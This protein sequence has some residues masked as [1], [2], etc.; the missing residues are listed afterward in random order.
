MNGA[1]NTNLFAVYTHVGKPH[2]VWCG[3]GCACVCPCVC[4]C[5]CAF[6]WPWEH[7][8]VVSHNANW[9]LFELNSRTC[10]RQRQHQQMPYE[11]GKQK[12]KKKQKKQ[13]QSLPGKAGKYLTVNDSSYQITSTAKI[14]NTCAQVL[15]DFIMPAT[16]PIISQSGQQM[17]TVVAGISA[18]PLCPPPPSV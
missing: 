8:I 16:L 5:V 15:S 12:K 10:H 1:I 11:Q 4:P 13:E 9:N 2:W 18:L 17:A 3:C 14:E 7:F 6:V